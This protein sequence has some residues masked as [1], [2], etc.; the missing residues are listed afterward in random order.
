MPCIILILIYLVRISDRASIASTTREVVL[1]APESAAA[2]RRRLRAEK[3]KT[4]K[5]ETQATLYE[6]ETDAKERATKG[7]SMLMGLIEV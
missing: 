3:E 7:T 5:L 2:K 1:S 4:V 6:E